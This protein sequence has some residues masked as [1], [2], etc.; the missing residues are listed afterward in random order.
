MELNQVLP[1]IQQNL[2]SL[3][4]SKFF[5]GI[6]MIIM[7]IAS[8]YVTLSFSKNQEYYLKFVLSRQFLIFA[9]AWMGTRDLILSLILTAVFIVLAD[10][11]LNEESDYCVLPEN[12]KKL[13]HHLDNNKDGVVSDKEINDAINI[14]EKSK[15]QK[16]KSV[17]LNM[18]NSL[19]NVNSMF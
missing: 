3:N 7:N 13:Y 9:I 19:G 14:L 1:F 5:A 4:N 15:K 8:R 12:Y 11:M 17:Q 10:F 16:E 2:S 18:L 6:I